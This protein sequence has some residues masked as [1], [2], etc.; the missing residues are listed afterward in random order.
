[1]KPLGI[2]LIIAGILMFIFSNIS[3][4]TEKKVV[5]LGSLEIT[6]KEKKT[7][8]WPSYAGGVAAICGV[9]VLLASR[10]KA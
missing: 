3:F 4:T 6:K 5:D 10:K 1:M 7:I 8:N 2:I 9:V